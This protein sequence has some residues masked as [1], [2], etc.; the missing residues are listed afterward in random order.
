MFC[1]ALCLS[2]SYPTQTLV[3]DW[4]L[5]GWVPLILKAS[6]LSSRSE[7]WLL[8]VGVFILSVRLVLVH[9]DAQIRG[10]V[11]SKRIHFRAPLP[12]FF[13]FQTQ[14]NLL[15]CPLPPPEYCLQL[16]FRHRTAYFSL[17][18]INVLFSLLGWAG[19]SFK[20]NLAVFKHRCHQ[21]QCYSE[22]PQ[23]QSPPH[24]QF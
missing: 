1:A 3:S 7:T 21:R 24:Q 12:L 19:P 6:K 8:F 2:L 5:C 14:S 22:L 20:F 16:S 13:V 17:T 9:K 15:G 10:I 4:A 11:N 18:S 23:Q